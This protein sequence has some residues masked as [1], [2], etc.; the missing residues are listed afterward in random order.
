V[1]KGFRDPKSKIILHIPHSSTKIPFYDG[2]LVDE[3]VLK[4]EQL[5][6]TD[7]YTNDLYDHPNI[8]S[9]IAGFSRIFCDVERFSDDSMEIM[10]KVGM[11]VIY[12]NRDNGTPLRIIKPAMRTRIIE[13]FYNPHHQRLYKA[14]EDQLRQSGQAFILDCH[15]FPNIPFK[16]DLN[17]NLNR[18]DFNIGTDEFHTSSNLLEVAK[19]FFIDRNFSVG[20]NTPY[21]GTIVPMKFYQKNKNVQSLMLE[22]NRRLYLN[23]NTNRK[24]GDYPIVKETVQEFISDLVNYPL[25]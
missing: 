19:Q 21:S 14:V 15:S 13:E 2:Y 18:P 10:S 20:I 9:V 25:R 1:I 8:I 23:D 24:S 3:K 17:Q 12:E 6:L 7:W 22:I 16:R 5:F 11:G 4:E